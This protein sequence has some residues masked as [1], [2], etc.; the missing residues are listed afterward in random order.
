M[1]IIL[2]STIP[3]AN[4]PDTKSMWGTY[5]KLPKYSEQI[6]DTIMSDKNYENYTEV[7]GMGLTGEK[8]EGDSTSYD[9][10][11]QGYTTTGTNVAY[12]KGFIISREA[13][14]DGKYLDMYAR[15]IYAL[16]MSK[17]QT[18]ETVA[19]NVLNRGYN[20]SYLGGDGVVLF[21]ASHPTTDGT[22]SN[23]LSVAADFSEVA[24]QDLVTQIDTAKDSAGNFISLSPQMLIG[25]PTLKF[26]FERLL[27]TTN[28]V[29]TAENDINAIKSLGTFPKGYLC[30]PFLSTDTDAFYIKTSGV[31]EGL[32]HQVRTKL[33]FAKDNDFDTDNEKYKMYWREKFFWVD[34]RAMYSSPGA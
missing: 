12:S 30:N 28:R 17:Y 8:S 3:P 20:S 14:D 16:G 32:V 19:A 1:P 7:V 5:D 33:E 34:W 13:K 23:T 25:H 11:T 24:I 26:D 2:R 21:S 29:D 31:M 18:T 22:Q 4:R 9:S 27:K 6:F 15:G 10:I